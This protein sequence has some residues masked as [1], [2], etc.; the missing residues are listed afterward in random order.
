M[1]EWR[2]ANGRVC[3][4]N[5]QF[6][7]TCTIE[8][9]YS[10]N[11]I[12]WSLSDDGLKIFRSD[13]TLMWN[14]QVLEKKNRKFFFRSFA[15]HEDFKDQ[16]VYLTQISKKQTEQDDSEKEETVRLVIWDLDDTFW[17]G[18][19]SEGEVKLRLDTLHMVRE[20]NNRGI[21]NAICSKNTYKDTRKIL[22]R[23]GYGTILYLQ[24]F[25][26]TPRAHKLKIL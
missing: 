11:E 20:L 3:S 13:K 2:Y 15:K 10:A 24:E 19:L 25:L 17:E 23:L 26:G 1:W 22:E 5:F 6:S 14:F 7:E 9:F 16:C 8:G 12:T 18:T 4:T 21:V